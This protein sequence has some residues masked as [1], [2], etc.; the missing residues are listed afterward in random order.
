MKEPVMSR[1][2]NTERQILQALEAQILETGMGGVGINAIAKRAGVSKELIYRYF[3]GMPG[4]LLAWMKEQD[5]WTR[6]PGL[7]A[8]EESS[9]RTPADLILTM[10]RAQI[11]TLLGNETL[12]EVRRWELIEQNDVTATLAERRENAARG[13]IERVD[14]LAPD[15]D[16]P[17]VA[18]VILA[19]AVYLTLRAK[20]A[21]HFL[22]L[23][24]HEPE[25]W[26]RIDKALEYLVAHSF[27][28]EL[29]AEALSALEARRQS[30]AASGEPV[31]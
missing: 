23:P 30:S 9:Q 17:A 31:V 15:V 24:L 8:A 19:G 21:T 14:E 2:A 7:L 10:L 13:F 26:A 4:L 6:N 1:R 16:V 11:E 3:D 28:D 22:G 20:T 29:N 25:G 27:P 12:R 18:G 5:F